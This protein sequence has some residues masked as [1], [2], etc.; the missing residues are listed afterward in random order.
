MFEEF[1]SG[2]GGM[3]RNGMLLKAVG[4]DRGLHKGWH[5]SSMVAEVENL[6]R[7]GAT[8]LIIN[9]KCYELIKI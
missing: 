4:F 8:L 6:N 9:I 2:D 3:L 5:T 7:I 1:I